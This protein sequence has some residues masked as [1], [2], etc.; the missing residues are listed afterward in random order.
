MVH[1]CDEKL[2]RPTA[3]PATASSLICGRDLQRSGTWLGWQRSHSLVAGITNVRSTL[4][5]GPTTS[6]RGLLVQGLL[7]GT[8]GPTFDSLLA[9]AL[10]G[11]AVDLL[12]TYAPFNLLL[13][14]LGGA[15]GSSPSQAL[16]LSNV[17]EQQ[18][19]QPAAEAGSATGSP[20]CSAW[21]AGP[22]PG[23]RAALGRVLT[24]GTH[25]I[26]NDSSQWEE[27]PLGLWASLGL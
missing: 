10:A 8:L 25:V 17:V 26:G 27:F 24:D 1:L 18:Q 21:V 22:G 9:L 3:L 13:V 11:Q 23:G 16:F 6:S 7:D 2:G 15:D 19:Q 4:P 14:R 12:E 5:H 20:S